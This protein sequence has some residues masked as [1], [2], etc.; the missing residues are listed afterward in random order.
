[1]VELVESESPLVAIVHE[2]AFGTDERAFKSRV[3]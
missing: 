1:M 2:V 3:S